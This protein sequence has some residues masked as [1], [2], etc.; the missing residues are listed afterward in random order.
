MVE[1]PC[2][3]VPNVLGKEAIRL[4]IGLGIIDR[5]L[6]VT[7]G[8]GR[9]VIPLVRELSKGEVAILKEQLEGVETATW[10]F[11]ERRKR[12]GSLLEALWGKLPPHLLASL[13]RSMDIIGRVAIVE[14]PPELAKYEDLLG[15][16]VM[17]VHKRVETVLAKLGAVGGELRLRNYKV[18]AGVGET[19]TVYREHGCIYHLD[20]TKVYFSPRLSRERW[21]ITQQVGEGETVIDMFAGVGPFSIQIGKKHGD[22]KVYAIDINPD[23]YNY[24]K[25]N[26]ATNK[27]EDRVFP[28]SG[29]ARVIIRGD[30]VGV[31]DRVIMNLPERAIEFIDVACKAL[32]SAGGVLH[33]YGFEAEPDALGRAREKLS[34]A[35]S[36]TRRVIEE[37]AG[38]RLVRPIA[39]HEW[40]VAVDAIVR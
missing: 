37:F 20:P 15:G 9:V 40:Q 19:E 23:A 3:S 33:Y 6:R 12:P 32:K 16:A 7:S 4:A 13:P 14:V 21:R 24:L 25:K 10:D 22:V 5:G 26:V 31:A 39:P 34:R 17:E 35:V 8:G 2:I 29:D 36:R 28:L 30:Y 1:A 11:Q 18:I 38:L 27:V